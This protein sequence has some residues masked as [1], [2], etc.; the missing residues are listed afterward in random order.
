MECEACRGSGRSC[1][2][3]GKGLESYWVCPVCSTEMCAI[4]RFEWDEGDGTPIRPRRQLTVH[5]SS[6]AAT[7]RDATGHRSPEQDKYTVWRKDE[8]LGED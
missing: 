4:V 1:D 7:H 3:C 2:N 5:E 6:C 8:L